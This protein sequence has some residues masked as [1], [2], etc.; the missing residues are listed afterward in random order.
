[1]DVSE[2][3]F[4]FRQKMHTVNWTTIYFIKPLLRARQSGLNSEERVFAVAACFSSGCY[5][6]VTQ[7]ALRNP[8][9]LATLAYIP[10]RKSIVTWTTTFR[11][12]AC[13]TLDQ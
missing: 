8:S 12:T 7:R 9:N 6:I 10:D 5:V 13:E 2:Y 11:L 3:F 4:K 1:M